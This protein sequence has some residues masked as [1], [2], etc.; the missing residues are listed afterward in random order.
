MANGTT[1][2]PK[3]YQ[4]LRAD[5]ALAR[6]VGTP[7][8]A[9]LDSA[10]SWGT[11]DLSVRPGAARGLS[12]S[13]I[14]GVP[15]AAKDIQDLAPISGR[16]NLAQALILRLLTPL[17]ALTPLGHPDY[18]C[19]LVELIGERNNGVNR[20]LARLYTIAAIGQERRVAK[21]V[22]LAVT[23]PPGFPDNIRIEL[24]VLPV[25]DDEPLPVAL[26]VT[27]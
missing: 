14:L 9:P 19:R 20:N 17:G 10:D 1:Q 11:L 27:L 16:E 22:S 8:S 26:E 18:G 7:S 12:P 3:T 24:V 2:K 5:I 21:L 13:R 23:V 15:V 4:R 6:Y 25:D